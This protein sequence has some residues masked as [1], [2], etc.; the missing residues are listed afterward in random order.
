MIVGGGPAGLSVAI[1]GHLA[2]LRTT[3]LDRS[4]P[5]TDKP[6]GEG[7]MPDGLAALER[8]GMAAADLRGRRFGGIRYRQ[9]TPEGATVASGR[10][11][12]DGGLGVRRTDLHRRLVERAEAVGVELRWGAS[13][14][15]I[16]PAG[17][18]W[19]TIGQ[20]AVA[21]GRILVGADGLRSRVR[22]WAGLAGR[23]AR[24]ARFGARRHFRLRPWSSFVE[25]WWAAG[26]EAYVTPVAEDEIG[27][28]LLWGRRRAGERVGFDDL[29][30]CFPVL[31]QRLAGAA[32]SSPLRGCGPL[33]QRVRSVR[34]GNLL[35]VGDAA[36][37]V[38]AITGEGLSLAFQQ[39]E[40]LVA[41]VAAGELSRYPVA[42][43]RLRRLP[44]AM[45]HLLLALA[46]RP[47]WRRRAIK[48]L[49]AEP[50]LFD[51]L[52]AVHARQS[53]LG[54]VGLGGAARLAWRFATV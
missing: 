47:A 42:C 43:R 49:A 4:R 13:V 12:V 26:C 23:P 14:E 29:L 15:G 27:V 6:C 53:G 5:P 25:V 19:R 32:A 34:R 17:E 20:G 39:A 51:R 11:P 44:D 45:T 54:A 35:L 37:Y 18:G 31:R 52:L 3:V 9:E 24:A 33:R 16:E 8:L 36:G 28:A 7:L 41:A 2:G 40:A 21:E 1:G 50:G 30:R 22:R 38:D 48:A 10:F 46:R